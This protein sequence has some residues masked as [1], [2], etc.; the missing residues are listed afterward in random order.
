MIVVAWLLC[1][2]GSYH[3]VKMTMDVA[4]SGAALAIVWQAA[5]HT[6]PLPCVS[7]R[8]SLR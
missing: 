4:V 1:Y 5:A 6:A 8:S 2:W 3:D 7:V